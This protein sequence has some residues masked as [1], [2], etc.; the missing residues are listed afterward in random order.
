MKV[1]TLGIKMRD[2]TFASMAGESVVPLVE[3]AKRIRD[4][5]EHD[6]A[7][8]IGGSVLSSERPFPVFRFR[9]AS[10]SAKKKKKK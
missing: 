8:A 10:V 1:A 5:G 3:A 2:G 7:A 9:C 4:S 6:G